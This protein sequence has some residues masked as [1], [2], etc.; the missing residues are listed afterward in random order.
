MNKTPQ[1]QAEAMAWKLARAQHEALRLSESQMINTNGHGIDYLV[2]DNCRVPLVETLQQE[3]PLP[4]LIAF[5][6]AGKA[7]LDAETEQEHSAAKYNATIV[8]E[9]LRATGKV[10]L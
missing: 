7:I 1:E 3:I 6:Q 4:E 5:A 8:L 10:E 9:A 2:W